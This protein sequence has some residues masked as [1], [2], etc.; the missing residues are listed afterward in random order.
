[1]L[2][3]LWLTLQLTALK[4]TL[5]TQEHSHNLFFFLILER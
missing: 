5:Q 2:L 4:N 3:A 1:M